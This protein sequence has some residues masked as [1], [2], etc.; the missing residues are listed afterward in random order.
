MKKIVFVIFVLAL[1]MGMNAAKAQQVSPVDF[2]KMNPYQMKSNPAAKLPYESVMS[3][4]IGNTN[5]SLQH[6]GLRFDNF[7]DFDAQ[8]V[9]T[10]LNLRKLANGLNESNFLGINSETQLFT[11]YRSVGKGMLT[12]DWGVK[13]RGDLRFSDDLFKLLAYGNSVF[14]GEGNPANVDVNLNLNAYRE[15]AVGYQHS[16]NEKL[17][18]GGRA[19]LLFGLANLATSNANVKLF[20]DPDSYALR[21]MEN[22]GVMASL[23]R[24]FTL[25]NGVL[26]ANGGFI[27]SDLFRNVGF[28]MDLGVEYRFNEHFGVM[29]A[30]NDLGF[31]RWKLNNV[32]LESKI[33]DAG[34]FYDDDSFL[35]NGLDTDQLQLFISDEYYRERFLDTLKQY[36]PM[37]LTNANKYTTGLNTNVLLRGYYDIDGK[38]RFTL[39][40]QGMFYNSGFRP[41]VTLAYSGSFFKKIDV[42]ASY[43][44]MKDSYDNIGLGLAFNLGVFH[45]YAA[46][47]NVIGLFKPL[48]TSALDAQVGI[49]FNLWK[50]EKRVA[51]E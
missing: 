49:V 35:F 48:N 10:T 13:V 24:V 2:M 22:V 43:T 19:K 42:C 3:I 7:F 37:E 27:W 38:N 21:I 8:G 32:K 9:P 16:I 51:D 41:A 25:E 33:E 46:S 12:F 15:F 36:F 6:T 20:T 17:S 40:A 31:I 4:A 23:P 29:A 11:L 26:N 47:N 30:V 5:L 44:V 39:Q 28:G 1:M 14:V 34:Q 50:A 45:I 18:I